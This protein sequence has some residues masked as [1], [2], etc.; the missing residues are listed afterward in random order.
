[1]ARIEL[2]FTSPA[3]KWRRILQAT[4]K[5]KNSSM[6]RLSSCF[7]C[8]NL[9]IYWPHRHFSYQLRFSD[10]PRTK[11]RR[12]RNHLQPG[13]QLFRKRLSW[14]RYFLQILAVPFDVSSSFQCFRLIRNVRSMNVPCERFTLNTSG[15]SACSSAHILH[16][17]RS[18]M[19]L[20][21]NR[22]FV[23]WIPQAAARRGHSGVKSS[24]CILRVWFSACW[25]GGQH[26]HHAYSRQCCHR[27]H[28]K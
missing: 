8:C 20:L 26:P 10:S 22:L 2:G 15:S 24:A 21:N 19:R 5:T 28:C 4:L 13:P 11:Q 27:S 18:L 3:P 7:A 16:M 14:A 12:T 25:F 1:M 17:I 9:V 6:K 23:D